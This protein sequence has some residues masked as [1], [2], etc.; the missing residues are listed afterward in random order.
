MT[1]GPLLKAARIDAGMTQEQLGEL[2]G[3]TSPQICR[4]E[5]GTDGQS[6]DRALAKIKMIAGALGVDWR[7]LLG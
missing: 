1:F 5:A 4:L 2:V 3:M 6:I 7:E